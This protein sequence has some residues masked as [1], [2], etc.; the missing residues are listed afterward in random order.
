MQWP[1]QLGESYRLAR[2]KYHIM[3]KL[4]HQ[5]AYVKPAWRRRIIKRKNGEGVA[6]RQRWL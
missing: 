2:R 6:P 4:Q 1:Q 3:A 5:L